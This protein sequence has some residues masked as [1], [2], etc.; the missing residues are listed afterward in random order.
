MVSITEIYSYFAWA[1]VLIGS[2]Q[3]VCLLGRSR[4]AICDILAHFTIVNWLLVA[5][6]AAIALAL[7]YKHTGG[8]PVINFGYSD[9]V[10]PGILPTCTIRA[11]G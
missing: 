1:T 4:I 6:G 7:G 9:L 8:H 2:V 5:I 3:V 11:G 10:H